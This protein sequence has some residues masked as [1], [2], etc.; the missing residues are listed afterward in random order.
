MLELLLGYFKLFCFDLMATALA[1]G[2]VAKVPTK[3]LDE[4]VNLRG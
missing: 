1:A 3:L 2:F 4:F